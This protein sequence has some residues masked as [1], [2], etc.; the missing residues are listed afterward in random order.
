MATYRRIHHVQVQEY[1]I[2]TDR[3]SPTAIYSYAATRAVRTAFTH[4]VKPCKLIILYNAHRAGACA[5]MRV[6]DRRL[7]QYIVAIGKK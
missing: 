1:P 5:Y 3:P 4:M 2:R 7:V 6:R